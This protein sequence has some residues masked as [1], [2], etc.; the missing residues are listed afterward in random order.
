MIFLKNYTFDESKHKRHPPGSNKGG[1]FAPSGKTPLGG[2]TNP[3]NYDDGGY[4]AGLEKADAPMRAW[5]TVP[6]N[7]PV[8]TDSGLKGQ[9]DS[10]DRHGQVVIRAGSDGSG[11]PMS[12]H[13]SKI[14]LPLSYL[15]QDS[16]A[17][18]KAG[19]TIKTKSGERQYDGLDR[20]GFVIGRTASGEVDR[21]YPR[22]VTVVKAK[23][24]GSITDAKG[25]KL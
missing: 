8:V 24:P 1:E 19:T 25:R 20:N 17:K 23:K 9:F 14:S 6:K 22:D 2:K 7:T 3:E 16:W 21:F 12:Y 4:A 10:V 18:T 15:E 13:P 5:A 11:R